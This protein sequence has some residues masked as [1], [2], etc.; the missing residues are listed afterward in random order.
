MTE[1]VNYHFY[2]SSENRTTGTTSNFTYTLVK[3]I[4][5][6]NPAHHL[7]IKIKQCTIPYSFTQ[8]FAPYNVMTFN[9]NVNGTYVSPTAISGG[10]NYFGLTITIAEASYNITTLLAEISTKLL[11][12]LGFGSALSSNFTYNAST[13]KATLGLTGTSNVW[14]QFLT[15]ND[16]AKM[17][18]ITSLAYF[19]RSGVTSV[20]VTSQQ[21]VNVSPVTNLYIRSNIL[22]QTTAYEN[23]YLQNDM[24]NVLLQVPIKTLPNTWIMYSNEL[25]IRSRLT[26]STV[27]TIQFQLSDNRGYDLSLQNLPM[28]IMFSVYEIRGDLVNENSSYNAMKQIDLFSNQMLNDIGTASDLLLSDLNSSGASNVPV[29]QIPEINLRTAPINTEPSEQT[30]AIPQPISLYQ[31][32]RQDGIRLS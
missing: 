16:I 6:T 14:V 12:V 22:K 23:V 1:I 26:N 27:D 5:L 17:I 24:S 15:T 31:P 18:G 20:N 2:I 29:A 19:G 10:T 4:I 3:P 30:V 7:E 28:Y 8:V 13:G 25:D 32:K 11:A 9:Y 21:P